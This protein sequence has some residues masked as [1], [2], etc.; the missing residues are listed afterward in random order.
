[1]HH[2]Q[3]KIRIAERPRTGGS[4]PDDHQY[5]PGG[6][7]RELPQLT[8]FNGTAGPFGLGDAPGLRARRTTNVDDLGVAP[9]SGQPDRRMSGHP[10]AANVRGQG[11]DRSGNFLIFHN[12]TGSH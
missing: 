3:A 9:M 7:L 1:M 4:E 11:N 8:G 12:N 2:K 6:P 10:A 5:Q